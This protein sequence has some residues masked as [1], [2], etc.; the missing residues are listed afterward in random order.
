MNKCW[1]C[2]HELIWQSDFDGNDIYPDK[3][4]IVSFLICSNC[5]AQVQYSILEDFDDEA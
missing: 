5:N 4:G 2:N 3:K 1:Y